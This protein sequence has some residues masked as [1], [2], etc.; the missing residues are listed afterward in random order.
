MIFSGLPVISLDPL[1]VTD[2]LD[3]TV[4]I[5][6]SR[7]VRDPHDD[8]DDEPLTVFV[9]VA[10]ALMERINLKVAVVCPVRDKPGD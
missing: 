2:R 9:E 3:D 8:C 7:E 1:D 5:D 6:D 4:C 10:R